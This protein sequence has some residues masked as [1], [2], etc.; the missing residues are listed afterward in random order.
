MSLRRKLLLWDIDGTLFLGRGCGARALVAALR[1]GFGVDGA[2]DGLELA[3]RTD[4]GI[5][6][7]LLASHG[8][9]PGEAEER[10][11]LE[12]LVAALGPELARCEPALTPGARAAIEAVA[13]RPDLA[14][15]LLTGNLEQ[16]ARLKLAHFDLW[17]FFPFGAWGDESAHRDDLGPHALARA[18]A[19]HAHAFAPEHT[20]VIGDTPHDI[21]C[22]RALG[23]CTIAVATGG[24]SAAELAALQP[25]AVLEDLAD[26]AALL[27]LIDAHPADA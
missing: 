2:I 15:G 24:H 18:R 9:G 4:R 3:G 7:A 21:A 17:R 16:A 8:L 11:L 25:T 27:A 10:R 26:T 23:A 22:G 14:Q 1:T 12:H 6:R 19:H 13:A 5:A 20:F